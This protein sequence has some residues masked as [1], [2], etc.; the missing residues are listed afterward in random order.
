MAETNTPKIVEEITHV[1]TGPWA[2]NFLSSD[3]AHLNHEL[4]AAPTRPNSATY[5]THVTMGLVET[6]SQGYVI[7]CKLLLN[8]GIGEEVFGPIQL[9]ARGQ[10]T[11]SKD[12]TKPLKITDNKALD[13]TGTSAGKGSGYYTACFVFIEGYTG[14]APIT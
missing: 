7:D 6:A 13:L 9:T 11:F 1:R 2:V 4:K 10:S 14:D 3:F 12:F 8:D 5:L